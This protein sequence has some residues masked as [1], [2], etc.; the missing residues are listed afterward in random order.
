[1]QATIVQLIKELVSLYPEKEVPGL[2]RLIMESTCGLSFTDLAL[3]R[4]RRL[5][6]RER[7]EVDRITKRLKQYE[8][9]QYILG[10]TE[11]YG[12]SFNVNPSVLIPRPETEEL[13]NWLLRSELAP[14]A[15]ILDIGTGSGCIAIAVKKIRP[16]V[17]MTALDISEEA[18]QAAR[19]NAHKN[20][21]N[22]DFYAAG[23][24]NPDLF[25][26]R[27]FDIFISN[28]PYVRECEKI[29]MGK[30]VL[31]WEPGEA[32][33]VPDDDPLK[34]YRMIV[35]LTRKNLHPGGWL[36]LEINEKMGEEIQELLMGEFRNIE[37]G[38]DMNGK[39]RMVRARKK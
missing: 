17:N 26:G 5:N 13:V 30:N 11:F 27:R 38:N 33:F 36:F 35:A 14:G 15:Q 19:R 7:E 23:I 12:L 10:K 4:F 29:R 37:I 21:V 1:M 34:Y 31:A 25:P 24:Q 20:K 6:D 9:I 22:V 39:P 16:E 28:P 32:L 8:P 2:V 3:K 18:I